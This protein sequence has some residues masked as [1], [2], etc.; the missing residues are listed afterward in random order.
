M[1]FL[2]FRIAPGIISCPE[3]PGVRKF[4]FPAP[5][6]TAGNDAGVRHEEDGKIMTSPRQ[7]L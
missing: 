6:A 5:Q 7:D 3:N 1:F 2:I 4:D